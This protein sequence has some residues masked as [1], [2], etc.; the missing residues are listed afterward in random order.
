MTINT[1]N[2]TIIA[3]I[4][5]TGLLLA[6]FLASAI[7]ILKQNLARTDTAVL[8]ASSAAELVFAVVA[9]T[10]LY[11]SFRK[12]KSPEIF[13]FIIFVVTMSLDSLK[14]LL[15]LIDVLR[16]SPYYGVF[17]TRAV[18]FGRFFGTLA[19]LF[20][21]LF[22]LGAEY[23]RIEIYLG[24]AFLLAFA[25]SAAVTI[26]MTESDSTML[27]Q[28]GN[29]RELGIIRVLF[30]SFGVLN[31]VLYAI[32]NSSKDHLLIAA[33]LALVIAGREIF[34]FGRNPVLLIG[35]FLMLIAGTTLFGERTHAVHLWS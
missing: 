11:L 29:S 26:D 5:L 19:V 23:Q 7:L 20:S 14:A 18:Y 31:Y 17:L 10:T 1:R 35:A 6:V 3:G 25:L 2:K 12:T 4:S 9:A 24:A 28:M 30:L 32:Q 13:F 33:G 21:G 16:L 34:S 8:L 27:Y 15:L 22:S